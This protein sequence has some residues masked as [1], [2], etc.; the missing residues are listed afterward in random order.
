M[1]FAG[2]GRTPPSRY[3][4]SWGQARKRDI[5]V[6][7]LSETLLLT[8]AGGVVGT[9]LGLLTRFLASRFSSMPT[10][11]T[12]T[13]L[14]LAFGISAAVGVTFGLY[15]AYRAANMDPIESLRHE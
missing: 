7:F 1:N 6:Q 11:I 9:M 13:S 2:L 5:V 15:P 3:G 4:F 8:L 12:G 10:V 14:V